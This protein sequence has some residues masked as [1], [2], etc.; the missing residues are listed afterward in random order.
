M[1]VLSDHLDAQRK[2]TEDTWVAATA[3]MRTAWEFDRNE[4]RRITT[5]KYAPERR[6]G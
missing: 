5:T 6:R 2:K 3:R 1:Q 4:D